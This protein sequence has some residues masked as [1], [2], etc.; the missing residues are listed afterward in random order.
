[1]GLELTKLMLMM[2]GTGIG[3]CTRIARGVSCL[4]TF[5]LSV[6][7]DILSNM[8]SFVARGFCFCLGADVNN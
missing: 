4:D 1:M 2:M 5:A 3:D 6:C 8:T 7:P